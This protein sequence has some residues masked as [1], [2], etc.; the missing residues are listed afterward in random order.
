MDLNQAEDMALENFRQKGFQI[1]EWPILHPA[2]EWRPRMRVTRTVRR[3][4][5]DAA[6]VVRENGASYRERHNW[7]PLLEARRQLPNLSIYF[8]IPEGER[9]DP[10]RTELQ[11]LGVGLYLIRSSGQLE[12]V[13]EDRVP[14]EDQAISYPIDPDLP[15][16]NRINVYKAFGNC[17]DYL[18]WVDK[19]FR[20]YGLELLEDYWSLPGRPPLQEI[21]ILGSTKVLGAELGRLGRQFTQL[22][23]QLSNLGIQVEMRILDDPG[24]LSSLHDRYIISKDIAF[25]LPPVGS[26]YKGQRGS[27]CLDDNPPDFLSLWNQARAI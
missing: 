7:D 25:N 10:L 11:E 22:Q 15:Y 9:L 24:L 2:L 3:Q 8:A 18:W 5:S 21:R 1:E 14:F 4:T 17:T 23:Q 12:K 26:L 19:H 13:Q 27:I 20:S 6:I 16:R